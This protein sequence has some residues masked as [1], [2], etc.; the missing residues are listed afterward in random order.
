MEHHAQG[1]VIDCDEIRMLRG[2]RLVLGNSPE[3]GQMET[4]SPYKVSDEPLKEWIEC[5]CRCGGFKVW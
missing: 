5:L 1:H 2:G 4:V 3:A